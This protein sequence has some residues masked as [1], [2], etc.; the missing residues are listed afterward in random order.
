MI[1]QSFLTPG[2]LLGYVDF[3][4]RAVSQTGDSTVYIVVIHCPT[5]IALYL[6]GLETA[7]NVEVWHVNRMPEIKPNTQSWFPS[8]DV[9][10]RWTALS[11]GLEADCLCDA[12]PMSN[13]AVIIHTLISSSVCLPVGVHMDPTFYSRHRTIE[14]CGRV[15]IARNTIQLQVLFPK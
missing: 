9:S 3:P 7:F 15:L 6:H 5:D 14:R 11:N 8:R 13:L 1:T 4:S 12:S 10:K 2:S